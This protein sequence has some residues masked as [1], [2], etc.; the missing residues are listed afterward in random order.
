M[1]WQGVGGKESDQKTVDRR[2]LE[3][4]EASNTKIGSPGI[5]DQKNKHGGCGE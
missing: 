3:R 2:D 4:L 1:R 5:Q